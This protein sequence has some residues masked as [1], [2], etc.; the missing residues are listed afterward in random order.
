MRNGLV[1]CLC[2]MAFHV[3]SEPLSTEVLLRVET[4]RVVPSMRAHFTMMSR[5]LEPTQHP[6]KVARRLQSAIVTHPFC[7]RLFHTTF[8]MKSYDRD[9]QQT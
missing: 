7:V 4:N 9:C 2:D 5:G 3:K 6:R 8:F 1:P